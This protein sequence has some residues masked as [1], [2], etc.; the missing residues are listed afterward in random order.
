M[1]KECVDTVPDK[2]LF[3]SFA[4]LVF[5]SF[6]VFLLRAIFSVPATA[7]ELA[8]FE[9]RDV[10][11]RFERSL[12]NTAKEIVRLFPPV[13]DELSTVFR[14]EFR[15]RPEVILVKG[16]RTFPNEMVVAFADPEKQLIV[17]DCSRVGA[18][19]FTLEATYKHELCHLLLH[20]HIPV[21]LPRWL[22][23]GVAQWVTG[24][25]AEILMNEGKS[26]LREAVLAGRLLR[27]D[28]LSVWF[29]EDRYSFMLA[30]EQSRSLVEYIVEVYGTSG[31]LRVLNALKAG[32]TLDDAME[33]SLGITMGELTGEWVSHL[34]RGPTWLIYLSTNLYEILFFFASLMV[35]IG[36]VRITVRRL[37]RRLSHEE[38]DEE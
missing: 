6:A 12:S 11:V 19:P 15:F 8:T 28:D 30:Y 2:G 13:K 38:E 4:S 24:G 1:M 31:L 20:A 9:N 26:E 18:H 10:V 37:K 23:E 35:I 27:F 17:I 16:N 29:P 14:W 7:D 5:L 34:G 36:A 25:F 33:N 3:R 22:D 32:N 21:G